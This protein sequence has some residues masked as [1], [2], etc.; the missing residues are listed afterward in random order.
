MT[1]ARAPLSQSVVDAAI[2]WAVKIR[3]GTP[4]PETRAAFDAWLARDAA[5]PMAWE[6]VQSMVGAMASV[7]GP[8]VMDTLRSAQDQRARHRVQRRAALRKIGALGILAPTVFWLGR[9]HLPWQRLL[10]DRSTRLGERRHVRLADGSQVDLNSDTAISF[11]QTAQRRLLTLRRGEIYVQTGHDAALTRGL[12]FFVQTPQ[13]LVQALGTRF[14]VRLDEDASRLSVTEGAVRMAPAAGAAR[15]LEAGQSGWLTR[16]QAGLSSRP[17][18]DPSAWTD[19]VI[20]GRDMRLGD[21]LAEI[22]R[23]R[24]GR[25]VCDPAIAGR[26][27]SGTFHI[28]DTDA[29]LRFLARTQSLVVTYRTALWVHVGPAPEAA[30]GTGAAV[31]N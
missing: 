1:V 14:T 10:A 31:T 25:V 5:H 2:D 21:V 19:G 29:L 7:R 15:V 23:Y 12:P 4:T 22:A 30:A 6:R 27:V 28:E 13:G 18:M 16:T 20:S 9:E 3:C 17:A 11:E 24:S 8:L 26:L